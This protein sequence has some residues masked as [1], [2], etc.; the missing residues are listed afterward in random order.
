MELYCECED[1]VK[2]YEEC[3]SLYVKDNSK[4]TTL[5]EIGNLIFSN[6]QNKDLMFFS[7]VIK[8]V[9]KKY[10][11]PE[12]HLIYINSFVRLGIH[13]LSI[14]INKHIKYNADFDGYFIKTTYNK[15][16]IDK[17]LYEKMMN[18]IE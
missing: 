13:N 12:I 5:D 10:D 14:D 1:L 6:Y 2:I 11:K 9:I 8:I 4:L 15:Y 7:L 3:Y 18:H 16:F 17:I